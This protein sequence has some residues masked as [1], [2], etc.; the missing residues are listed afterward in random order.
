MS[1]FLDLLQPAFTSLIVAWC[2]NLW[3]KK[4]F[5]LLVTVIFVLAGVSL[6]QS[7]WGIMVRYLAFSLPLVYA[8]SSVLVVAGR[9]AFISV[10]LYALWQYERQTN[11]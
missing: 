10:M 11:L 7:V 9:L 2:Y 8:V 5:S 1:L 6:T 4:T 3:R